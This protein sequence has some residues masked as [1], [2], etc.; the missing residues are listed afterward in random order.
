M[1]TLREARMP[2]RA[3]GDAEYE[4]SRNYGFCRLRAICSHVSSTGLRKRFIDECHSLGLPVVNCLWLNKKPRMKSIKGTEPSESA[5]IRWVVANGRF[6]H[7]TKG[8]RSAAPTR[9]LYRFTFTLTFRVLGKLPL[10]SFSTQQRCEAEVPTKRG[11]NSLLPQV[12]APHRAFGC[13]FSSR[14][15]IRRCSLFNR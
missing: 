3:A 2:R 9:L 11:Q 12:M 13:E 7:V 15:I 8:R 4:T 14:F 6:R 5:S 1:T 10:D